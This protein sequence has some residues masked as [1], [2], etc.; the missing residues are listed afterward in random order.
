M[1][2]DTYVGIHRWNSTRPY[3]LVAKFRYGKPGTDL[4]DGGETFYLSLETVQTRIRNKLDPE[5]GPLVRI[6]E[7]KQ[8]ERELIAALEEAGELP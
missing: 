8:A 7:E 4:Y 6:N 2:G 3:K 1:A 5:K